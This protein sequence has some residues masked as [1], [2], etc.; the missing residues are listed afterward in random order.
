MRKKGGKDEDTKRSLEIRKVTTYDR[1]HRHIAAWVDREIENLLVLGPGGTGKSFAYKSGLGNRPYHAFG[2]RLTPLQMYLALHDRPDIPVVL[3]DIS[4]LLK[5]DDFRDLLKGLLETGRRVVRWGTTTPKLE[6]RPTQFVCTSSVLIVLNQV[7]RR[8]P[9]LEAILDRCDAIEFVP[10]KREVIAHMRE[11]FPRAGD[12]IDLL[13]GLPVL[14]SLRTL[15]KAKQWQSSRHLDLVEELTAECGV[16]PAVATMITIM[17]R[18]PESAWCKEYVRQTGLTDRTYRRNKR[19]AEQILECRR[20]A[21]RC[22]D[23]RL[24]EGGLP[25]GDASG[26]VE[27]QVEDQAPPFSSHPAAEDAAPNREPEIPPTGGQA[28]EEG[29]A[30]PAGPAVE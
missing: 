16:P 6:G 26:D 19:H 22:P 2:G 12:L 15:I 24:P 18:F 20:T 9:D 14:P 11:V 27:R 1:F 29:G 30:P 25:E 7:P 23:V 21:K 3:D 4:A 5:Q 13:A 17:E 8:D 10:T 28:V